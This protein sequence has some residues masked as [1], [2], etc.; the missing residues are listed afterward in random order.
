MLLDGMSLAFA[1]VAHNLKLTSLGSPLS[2]IGHYR[3]QQRPLWVF[4]TW[5]SLAGHTLL[6]LRGVAR[7][8]ILGPLA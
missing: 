6:S 8:T 1:G 7:E 3:L 4:D 5:S 2:A